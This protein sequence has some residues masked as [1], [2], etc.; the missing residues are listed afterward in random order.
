MLKN[1]EVCSNSLELYISRLLVLLYLLYTYLKIENFDF[2]HF[3]VAGE[4]Q[5]S[6][7]G[8]DF[9]HIGVEKLSYCEGTCHI[10]R[11]KKS[12]ICLKKLINVIWVKNSKKMG[13]L[14]KNRYLS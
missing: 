3:S 12:K 13:N 8:V 4:V 10:V 2:A 9:S 1:N 11:V 5:N 6:H 14:S 7:I